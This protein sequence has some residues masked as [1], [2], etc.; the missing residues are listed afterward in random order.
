MSGPF[1]LFPFA[2]YQRARVNR[3]AL[4][5]CVALVMAAAGIAVAQ[6]GGGHMLFGDFKVDESKVAGPK[7]L[8]FDLILYSLGRVVARQTV[9]INSRYRFLDLANGDY[10]L[11]VESENN[12]VAR[13]RLQLND[14]NKTDI[15]QDIELEWR[16]Q[17]P[18][19]DRKRSQ[20]VA[21]AIDYQRTGP[22]AK[23]FAKAEKAL[24]QKEF[25]QALLLFRQIL[26]EDQQDYQSWSELG[27]VYLMQGNIAEADSAYVRATEANPTF[28]QSFLNL[29][30][31][32][33]A[34][35]NFATAIAPLSQA[36]KLKPE[37]ADAN[38]LLGEC[39][40]Q[41]KQGSKAVVY[42]YE[43]LKLEPLGKAEAHLRLA[44]LYHGAGLRAKAAQEYE[45]FLRKKPD[46]RDRKK[47]EQY[48]LENKKG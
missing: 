3:I 26:N 45:E 9:G 13:I 15:R 41:I 29:G 1:K 28:F 23:R 38:Y 11:V 4:P 17:L 2:A 5:I 35:K 48:I 21:A 43:A 33:M 10:E 39:Y 44:A 8:S 18:G 42:L 22:N 30:K 24:D 12:E 40:L 37:S 34:D 14:S 25:S 19:T 20:V 16:E 7:P 36:V 27:T 6:N 47:L 46:Y 31:L 32:R